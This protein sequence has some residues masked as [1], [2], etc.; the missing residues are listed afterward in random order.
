MH[1]CFLGL[2]EA[3]TWLAGDLWGMMKYPYYLF[4]QQTNAV[5]EL[6]KYL[7]KRWKN[8]DAL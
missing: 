7:E 6:E 2:K 4:E 8:M 1:V 5:V 3:Y